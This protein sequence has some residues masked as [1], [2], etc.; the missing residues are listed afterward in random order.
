M[1]FL[2]EIPKVKDPNDNKQLLNYIYALE[3]Q[4]RYVY[5]HL[6][7]ENL[8]DGAV[9]AN[10]LQDGSITAEKISAPAKKELQLQSQQAVRILAKETDEKFAEVE[11]NVNGIANRVSTAEGA[12]T[13]ALQTANSIEQ[14]VSNAEGN[15]SEAIQTA[16]SFE[17]R[18]A[19][20]EGNSSEAIQTAK[21]VE[22]KIEGIEGQ[23]DY[24][25]YT[26]PVGDE[27]GDTWTQIAAPPLTWGDLKSKTWNDIKKMRWGEIYF[28]NV[29]HYIWNGKEWVKMLDEQERLKSESRIQQESNKIAL[30]VEQV[31]EQE[32]TTLRNSKVLVTLEGI[33]LGT[34]GVFIVDSGNFE[35]D[36]D[37][38]VTLKGKVISG[39][40]DIGGWEIAPGN[41][42]SGSGTNHVRLSTENGKPAIWAGN[43]NADNAP[44]TV[45]KDGS[46]KAESGSIG[47]WSIAPGNLSSGSGTKHVRLSTEDATYAIWAGAEAGA[48]AP[49]RVT[50]DGKVY[51]T[52]LYV[53]DE[54]GNAQ[55]NPVNLSGS[56]WRTNRAIR[57]MEVEGNTLTITLYDGTSV[58]FSK[59]TV[60]SVSVSYTGNPGQVQVTVTDTNGGT[61]FVGNTAD[62]GL[63]NAALGAGTPT[64]T[65]TGESGSYTITPSIYYNGTKVKDGAVVSG[66][67]IYNAGWNECI[68]NCSYQSNVY[69][70]SQTAPGTLYLKVGNNYTSVGS[71]WVRTTRA[72]GMYT[73]PSKK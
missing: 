55:A 38:N 72:T 14:R 9:G 26:E 63:F 27:I 53:T 29:A 20:A 66:D 19:D 33:Q 68:D 30:R 16:N 44:F 39:E 17:Q 24:V 2:R 49:F 37:G 58:N 40:G 35:I 12:A 56:W 1:A 61:M 64:A 13:E 51:L 11:V 73:I 41:L 5:A 62:G 4:L 65:I 36:A 32:P 57:T 10:Q 60:G 8:I 3:E 46:M 69:T 42:S 18:L 34:S 7:A 48:S 59:A 52:K 67:G 25:Q 22:S 15:A 31:A 21:R 54:N 45:G 6:G 23:A 28:D 47:G 71:D 50:P 70:I 43:E